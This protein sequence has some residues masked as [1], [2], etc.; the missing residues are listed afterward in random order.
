MSNNKASLQVIYES[1]DYITNPDAI[2][3]RIRN[4]FTG[5]IC[6]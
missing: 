1:T 5:I 4:N 2:I 6:A 3:S